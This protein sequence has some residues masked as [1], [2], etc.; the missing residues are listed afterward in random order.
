M[1]QHDDTIILSHMLEHAVEALQITQ[2]KT[3][4]DVYDDRILNLALA[5]LLEIIG[6]AASRVPQSTRD[7]VSQ[8]PW[9]AIVAMRNRLT[10]G[11]DQV[12]LDIIWDVI[13][14]DLPPLVEELRKIL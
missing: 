10:H 12:D 6:E 11:Y 7:N 2:G 3:R 1:T 4:A 14:N 8:I 5:R 9:N 13:Q